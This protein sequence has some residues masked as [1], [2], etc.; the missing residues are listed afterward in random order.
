MATVVEGPPELIGKRLLADDAGTVAAEVDHPALLTAV[1]QALTDGKPSTT[2]AGALRIYAEPFL[3]APELVVVG[4]GHVAQPIAQLGKLLGFS[5][6]VIDDRVEY[7]NRDRFPTADR[8][9]CEEFLPALR[10]LG[11]GARHHVVLV[12]R[13]H[14]HDMECLREVLSLPL[15]YIGMIG[16]RTRVGTVFRMLTE[17]HVADPKRLEWVHAPIGLDIGACT[18]AEIAVSVAAELVKVRRGGTGASLSH[19]ARNLVHGR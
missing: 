6:T 13:G 8:V 5:V 11:L 18:P 14:H 10:G 12:T 4:G 3:P 1:R 19:L 9:I 15:A 17:E 2:R 16:S 7:A